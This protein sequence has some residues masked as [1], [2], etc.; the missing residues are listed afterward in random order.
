MMRSQTDAADAGVR[1]STTRLQTAIGHHNGKAGRFFGPGAGVPEVFE[2]NACTQW[3]P[4]KEG[5]RL[6]INEAV[7]GLRKVR[8]ENL[9][10]D[11]IMIGLASLGLGCNLDAL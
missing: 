6:C 3:Q 1:A 8:V 4:V 7:N 2:N 5:A 11:V 9:H 10:R